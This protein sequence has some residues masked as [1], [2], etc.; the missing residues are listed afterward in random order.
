VCFGELNDKTIK[1]LMHLSKFVSR[2]ILK[3]HKQL[4]EHLFVN[5]YYMSHIGKDKSMDDPLCTLVNVKQ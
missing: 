5:K 1:G 3:I 2:F 4:L